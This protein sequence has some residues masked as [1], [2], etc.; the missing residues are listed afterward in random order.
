MELPS[1]KISLDAKLSKQEI[2]VKF[3][4]QFLFIVNMQEILQIESKIYCS[5]WIVAISV[6]TILSSFLIFS[7]QYFMC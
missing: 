4:S 1:R 3:A 5:V 7:T 6:F 2:F